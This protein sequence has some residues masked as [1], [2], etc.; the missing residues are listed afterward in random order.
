MKN[1]ITEVGKII[2][3]WT[4]LPKDYNDISM[5]LYMQQKLS[6]YSFNLASD[7]A[8]FKRDYNFA[9]FWRKIN[10]NKR[11]NAFIEVGKS[12]AASESLAIEKTEE[13]LRKEIEAESIC[14][15]ADVLLKQISG[16]LNSLTQRIS[17]LKK[18]AERTRFENNLEN[19]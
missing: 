12:A 18:E 17:Y 11:K 5:L 8:D 7:S 19:K 9:Y 4:N 3:W 6:G 1:A 14:Y 15:R 10:V 16:I 2:E 13:E